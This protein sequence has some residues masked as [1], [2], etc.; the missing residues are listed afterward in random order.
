M[1]NGCIFS[2]DQVPHDITAIDCS[3]NY[4]KS[5]IW[6]DT[7]IRLIVKITAQSVRNIFTGQQ[8]K[9][10]CKNTVWVLEG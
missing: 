8:D 3:S 7:D 2:H 6:A 1:N 4:N 9:G 5:A 10:F